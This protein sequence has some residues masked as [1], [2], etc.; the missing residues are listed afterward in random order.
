MT[1]PPTR[2]AYGPDIGNEPWPPDEV[3]LASAAMTSAARRCDGD[4]GSVGAPLKREMSQRHM[5]IMVA[6]QFLRCILKGPC[7]EHQIAR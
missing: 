4:A 5:A 7:L 3:R 6:S 2:A 1:R